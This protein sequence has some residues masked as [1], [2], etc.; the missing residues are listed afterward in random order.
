MT[1]ENVQKES[2][3]EGKKDEALGEIWDWLNIRQ[4]DLPHYISYIAENA[5]S[6][7]T[8]QKPLFQK[9]YKISQVYPRWPVDIRFLLTTTLDPKG[10][11]TTNS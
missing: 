3:F 1:K 7:T 6:L 5:F 4:E 10:Y 11:V 9:S 2:S 8:A